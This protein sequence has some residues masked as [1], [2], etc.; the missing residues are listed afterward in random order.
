MV[1]N[2]R[3]SDIPYLVKYDY[4]E[5]YDGPILFQQLIGLILEFI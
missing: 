1:R 5:S 4:M 2:F 3:N